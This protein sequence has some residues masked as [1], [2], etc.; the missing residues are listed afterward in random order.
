MEIILL[1]NFYSLEENPL[2]PYNC[3]LFRIVF[4]GNLEVSK[5]K[6][7]QILFD[8]GLERYGGMIT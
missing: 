1:I 8:N 2:F 7:K 6:F 5:L 3:K 4:V